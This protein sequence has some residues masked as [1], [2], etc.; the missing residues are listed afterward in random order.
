MGDIPGT[1][2]M[3]SSIITNPAPGD[4]LTENQDFN[5]EFTV[6]NLNAGFFTNPDVTYY[7]SPQQLDNGN[8]V[9]HVHV[10]I[11]TLGDN[12]TPQEAPDASTFA[13][14]KGV[15]DA[16]D[17][18]GHLLA[19][20]TG[21]LPAGSYR[22]CLMT[23][24]MNH[25]PVL[26]PVAQRGAQDDCTKF[27]VGAGN[28]GNGGNGNGG[29]GN[30]GNGNGGNGDGGN[31]NGGAVATGTDDA[32]ASATTTAAAEGQQFGGQQ[33]GQ[34]NTDQTA[35]TSTQAFGEQQQGGE[36]AVATT[37]QA[38]GG[39]QQ[40]A[41]T[42]Q[43]FQNGQQGGEQ[44][45]AATTTQAFQ[46]PAA[47]TQA[48]QDPAA[49]TQVAEAAATTAV[50]D[51]NQGQQ[52]TTAQAAAQTGGFN[53]GGFGGN[54]QLGGQFRGRRRQYQGWRNRFQNRPYVV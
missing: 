2:N 29:N 42:T 4:D 51:F 45:I 16:G 24:A 21:G 19:T 22:A 39:E 25:Q 34:Q 28:G 20:V 52:Q 32:A 23:A 31:G 3:V 7:T 26:M 10:T 5:V 27:T 36:Q 13:F 12:L 8:I 15:D 49:T 47:T 53:A 37:T 38:F 1:G 40:A 48:F 43:A 18:N 30:G 6:A 41:T 54:G 17:G 35:G 9:G 50:Q 44:S 33:G 11:Q 14:F 46:D